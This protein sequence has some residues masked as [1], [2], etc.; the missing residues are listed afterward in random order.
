MEATVKKTT[1][2]PYP[3]YKYSGV[4]W[5]GDIPEG[6]EV[7]RIKYLFNIGRGRVIA[8]T[9]LIENGL[10]PVYSSQT[11]DNGV[12][13]YINSFDF[14]CKQI[15]W[16]TDGANAG[17]VFLRNGKHN[18]TN[19]CGTLQANNNHQEIEFVAYALQVAAQFYKRPDTN[20]AKIMNGEMAEIFVTV[21]KLSEQVIIANFLDDKTTKIDQAIGIKQK[22]IELLKERRQIL[23]HKAVTR[24]L[25]DKVKLKDSGVEWIGEIPEHWTVF[26]NNILFQERN[27]PG[28]ENLPLLSVSIH[29]AVSS[30]ELNDEENI[31]GKIKIED[32][33][34]YKL[35]KTG[36]IVF[37]MMRAWQGAIGAVSIDGMVSPAYVVAKPKKTLDSTFIEFQYRTAKFIQQID[38]ASK[39]ITDFRKRLYWNEFKQLIT[40]LPMIDEQK[41]IVEYIENTTTKIA[42]AISLKEQEIDKLKEYKMS[43]IDG[44]VTGKV[45]VS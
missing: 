28:N 10:Y 13:G 1:L 25:N 31:R 12:L 5:L 9:E 14:D 34:S 36:D 4:T 6:W 42:T 29:T 15:T 38:R 39:G 45:K 30:N 26:R 17:T 43:L 8:Q 22:Q 16:T 33:S 2:K 41:Q 7:K 23:I 3:D 19:V 44:V 35:V 37:N 11:K 21:P 40:V 27:E 24:G 20:G 32:K 18:C